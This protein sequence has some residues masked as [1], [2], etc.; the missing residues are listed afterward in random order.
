VGEDDDDDGGLSDQE[1]LSLL[2]YRPPT[3]LRKTAGRRRLCC[4]A[5]GITWWKPATTKPMDSNGNDAKRILLLERLDQFMAERK[6]SPCWRSHFVVMAK[7]ENFLLAGL[8]LANPKHNKWVRALPA[9]TWSAVSR[10]PHTRQRQCVASL[11]I[12]R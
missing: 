12:L 9:A 8:V 11:P 2:P 7:H 4:C 3:M 10:A 1:L 6:W 5:R